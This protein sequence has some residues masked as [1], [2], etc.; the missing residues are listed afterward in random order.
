[1][2]QITQEILLLHADLKGSNKIQQG[3]Y[4]EQRPV[5]TSTAILSSLFEKLRDARDKT[6]VCKNRKTE[7]DR[8]TSIE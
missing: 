6:L 5:G 1:M 2:A 8:M 7:K 3:L 4:D